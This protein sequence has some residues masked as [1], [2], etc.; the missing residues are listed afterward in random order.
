[1]K[2]SWPTK[3]SIVILRQ[4][5]PARIVAPFCWFGTWS[6]VPAP[7]LASFIFDLPDGIVSAYPAIGF[8]SG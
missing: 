8:V 1:M 4:A 6:H 3:S 7:P 5:T 2:R